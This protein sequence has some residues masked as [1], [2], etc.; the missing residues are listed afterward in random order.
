MIGSDSSHIVFREYQ[1]EDESALSGLISKNFPNARP[2]NEVRDVWLWQFKNSLCND[3]NV[4]V[5][6]VRGGPIVAQYAV[7]SLAM[8]RLGETVK[9]AISSATVTDVEYRGRKLFVTLAK[10]LYESLNR[11]GY[12]IVYGFPNRQSVQGFLKGLEWH[13]VC[14]FPVYVKPCAFSKLYRGLFRSRT[15]SG[16]LGKLSG[17]LYSAVFRRYYKS[18]R[19]PIAIVE[20]SDNLPL[21]IDDMWRQTHM[22]HTVSIIRDRQYLEWR[23]KQKPFAAYKVFLIYRSGSPIGFYVTHI[24]RQDNLRILYIMELVIARDNETV[25]QRALDQISEQA[26]SAEVDLISVLLMRNNPNYWLFIK[27]G[28][29]PVP[30]K[31]FPQDIHFCARRISDD[32]SLDAS[33]WFITWGDLDVL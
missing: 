32:T 6:H 23:Y 24:G 8:N 3:I 10:R 29:L 7:M 19:E 11:K 17:L 27:N 33:H 5:A 21:E 22:I 26:R 4:E 12:A 31:L 13:E 9:G 15:L 2:A 20:A 25:F 30:K 18:Y 14:R 16:L 1:E 28:F